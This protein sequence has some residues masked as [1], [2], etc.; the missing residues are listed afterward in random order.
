MSKPHV[1]SNI[2][3]KP[4]LVRPV[5]ITIPLD[6]FQQHLPETFFQP[7]IGEMDIDKMLVQIRVQNLR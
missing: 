1:L 5:K 4:M 2:P 3:I 7:K 6:T